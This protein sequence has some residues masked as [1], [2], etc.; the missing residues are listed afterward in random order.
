MRILPGTE[1][2]IL[3]NRIET[4]KIKHVIFDFDGTISL[5]REG[6]ESI[7][8]SMM[9]ACICG[10][11][12]PTLEI[13]QHVREYIDETTGIQTII[14]MQGLVQMVKRYRL[15]PS[16]KILDQWGYKRLYNERLLKR[17]RKRIQK[18]ETKKNGIAKFTLTG[19]MDFCK[20]LFQRRLVMYLASGT[21][22]EDVQNEA[23]LLQ[24]DHYFKGGIYGAVGS[25]EVYS[26][27]LVI[28]NILK[29]HDL[30]GSELIV[31]GDGPVEIQNAKSNGAIAVGIASYEVNRKG[32]NQKKIKRL[33]N[34]GC[35]ILI[36]DFSDGD[37]LIR[38]LFE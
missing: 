14:Q 11:H 35:D 9:I 4:G 38:Y 22:L 13:I 8:E 23:K 30:C 17:V 33:V 34:A 3:N 24:V 32:W 10:D 36:P 15:V 2:K 37:R 12:R 25:I 1:I 28:K 21:D 6:W 18:I 19:A 29:T 31:F 16:D 20:R 5:L 26:K 27:A 7:M